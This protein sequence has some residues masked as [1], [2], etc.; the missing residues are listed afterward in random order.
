MYFKGK[1]FY[2][3]KE[4]QKFCINIYKFFTVLVFLYK[5]SL[6]MIFFVLM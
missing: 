5:Y 4:S 2:L 1:T 3:E 6:R